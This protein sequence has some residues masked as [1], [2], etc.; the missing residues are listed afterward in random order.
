ML[1]TALNRLHGCRRHPGRRPSTRSDGPERLTENGRRSCE[2]TIAQRELSRS[3]VKL[4]LEMKFPF[5]NLDQEVTELEKRL[6]LKTQLSN[7]S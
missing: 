3:S 7:S 4:G 2:N 5:D 6:V 1:F